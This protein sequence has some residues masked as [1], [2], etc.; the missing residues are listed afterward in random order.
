MPRYILTGAPGA[1]K[2]A[3]LRLLESN[4]HAV[5]EEA[6]TDVI[7]LDN[8]LG[9]EE[10][11]R[12]HT[13]IDKIV[14]LQRRRQDAVRAAPSTAVFFDRSPVCTLALSRYLGFAPSR[15]LTREVDRVTAEGGYETTVFFIRNQ[16]FVQATAA[17]RI[18]FED[19]LVFERL[20]EQTYRDLGFQL[21]EI[22]AGPLIDR[23]ALIEQTI[24]QLHGIEAV[25][26]TS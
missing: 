17:R 23:V 21:V 13:F 22:P 9:H 8:A 7:T 15:L 3:V 10:P 14:T 12:D 16:G 6:A 18:S 4:G 2:T 20:H 25:E 5:V 11:W 26:S 24:E 19:S 1:G